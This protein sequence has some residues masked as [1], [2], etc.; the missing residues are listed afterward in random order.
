LEKKIG[1][2]GYRTAHS[3]YWT[4]RKG[5][6]IWDVAEPTELMNKKN[7]NALARMRFFILSKSEDYPNRRFDINWRTS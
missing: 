5:Y 1:Q 2:I 6:G 4:D 7:R 3:A